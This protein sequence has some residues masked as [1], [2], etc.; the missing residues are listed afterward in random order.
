MRGR[1]KYYT[2]NAFQERRQV[3]LWHVGV[4]KQRHAETKILA[5][6]YAPDFYQAICSGVEYFYT[7]RECDINLVPIKF[8]R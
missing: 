3:T 8:R 4:E 5:R 6:E 2:W 7:V 1:Y